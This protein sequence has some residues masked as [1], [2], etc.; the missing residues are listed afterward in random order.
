MTSLK[1]LSVGNSFSVDTMEHLANILQS[2]GVAD[3]KLGNLYIGGCSIRRHY[4]N[5]TENLPLYEYLVNTGDGWSSTFEQTIADAVQ[6]EEWDIISIQHGTADGS[7]NSDPA[8]YERFADLVSRIKALAPQ[9]KIAFNMTWVGEPYHSHPEI[10]AHNGDVK[11]LYE[12]IARVMRTVVK[13]TAGVDIV[14]P[15]G[16]AIQN[17]RTAVD[18]ELTRDG[19]HL[20][21]GLGRYIAALT[22]LKALTG[23]DIRGVSFM[24]DDVTAAQRD[25]AVRAAEAAVKTPFEVTAL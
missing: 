17:A 25:I 18:V 1:I 22:F 15:T 20:S 24:P 21:L 13:P 3:I 9:A 7:R 16:T 2:L 6:S 14:S 11:T 19:Y 8:C 12:T 23:L 10:V 5:I 4:E